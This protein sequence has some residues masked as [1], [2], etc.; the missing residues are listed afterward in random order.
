MEEEQETNLVQKT[1]TKED[2]RIFTC[3]ITQEIMREP[4]SCPEGYTFERSAI[5]RWLQSNPRN[6]LTRTS[7]NPYDLVPNRSLKDLIQAKDIHNVAKM[8][9]GGESQGQ[10]VHGDS[11]SSEPNEDR[12]SAPVP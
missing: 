10:A 7:L 5:I 11:Q 9:E 1:W 2:L 3:P 12:G 8:L 6:P 4:V